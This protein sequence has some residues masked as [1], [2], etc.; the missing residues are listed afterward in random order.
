MIDIAV[1]GIGGFGVHNLKPLLG[2]PETADFRLVGA[3][4]PHA[5]HSPLLDE[6]KR[7]EIP[8]F[9]SL[10]DFYANGRA[11]LVILSTPIHLHASQTM[12]AL[13]HGSNV[14]CE[15]PLCATITEA[16]QMAEAQQKAGKHVAI[17]YQASFSVAVQR[18][19]A[20][21]L[22]GRFGRPIRL[23]TIVLWPREESYY[24]RN[25]WAGMIHDPDGRLILDSPVNNACAHYLHN[26][27][28]V[29]GDRVSTSAVP[30]RVT[31]ELYRANPIEN[32]DTAAIRCITGKNVE[33]LFLTSHATA[34]Q[35]D[36]TFQFEFE[37]AI[38]EAEDGSITARTR[39]GTVIEYGNINDDP[40]RK[41]WMTLDGVR[42]GEE[43]VCGI[44]AATPQTQ[45]MWAAQHSSPIRSFPD[46]L[47][48]IVPSKQ[49]RQMVVDGLDD[50][51]IKCY[52]QAC[53]PADLKAP[54]SQPGRDLTV[55]DTDRRAL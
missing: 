39:D 35:K 9:D 25:R 22:A 42:S 15:K 46:A 7:R 33:L 4:D 32:Y 21:I 3:V 14:L 31:A 37:Q 47:V 30:A 40:H 54:W 1:A 38:V 10:E 27:L 19:K 45:C 18:V 50:I 55:A 5:S 52:E 12:T 2:A 20:D 17:G 36:P 24:R 51:L 43:S 26:M 49:S 16:N 23:K 6:L 34:A 13:R 41:I 11:D 29:L 44:A 48:R 8:L 28:Y 53:L